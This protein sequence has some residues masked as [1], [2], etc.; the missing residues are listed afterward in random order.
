MPVP[1]V[2]VIKDASYLTHTRGVDRRIAGIFKY[3]LGSNCLSLIDA[4]VRRSEPFLVPL[5]LLMAMEDG[6]LG[7][8]QVAG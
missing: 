8:E 2:V 4:D 3:H 1:P 5:S 7:F 6:S